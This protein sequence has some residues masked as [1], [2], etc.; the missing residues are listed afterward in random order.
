MAKTIKGWKVVKAIA[1]L[2]FFIGTSIVGFNQEDGFKVGK[3]KDAHNG[4]NLGKIVSSKLGVSEALAMCGSIGSCAG[5]GGMC[6]SIGSCG[7]QGGGQGGGMCGSIGS[8][9]GQ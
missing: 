6:G 9:S 2:I 4:F 8:C 7:G 1:S 3:I 5:G